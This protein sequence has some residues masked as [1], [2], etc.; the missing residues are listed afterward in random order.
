M[1]LVLTPDRL[2]AV[3]E[4]LRAFPPFNRWRL[5]PGADIRFHVTKT[6]AHDAEWWLEDDRHH[7][8]LSEKRAGHIATIIRNMGHEMIHVKQRQAKTETRG[9]EHNA[10]FR[11]ISKRLCQH[12][13]WDLKEFI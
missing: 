7:I 4:M 8:A 9:V 6:N 3:Y 12:Y 13:G 11:R 2:A 5:P 10:E 1:S